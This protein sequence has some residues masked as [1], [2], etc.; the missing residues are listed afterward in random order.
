MST[1]YAITSDGN[2]SKFRP[3]RPGSEPWQKIPTGS[4]KFLIIFALLISFFFLR[5]NH[6]VK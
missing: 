2:C 1:E 3:D 4:K 5:F 6:V